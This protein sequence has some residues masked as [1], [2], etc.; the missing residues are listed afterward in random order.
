[1]KQFITKYPVQFGLTVAFIIA[2]TISFFSG[3]LNPEDLSAG[4]L[5]ILGGAIPIWLLSLGSKTAVVSYTVV[6]IVL[7][8]VAQ[9]FAK[10]MG[11]AQ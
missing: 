6:G 10:R 3:P 8:W 4:Q 9:P 2:G 7:V 11:W 1:M 5:A